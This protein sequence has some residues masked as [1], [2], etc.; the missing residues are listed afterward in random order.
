MQV[1]GY[2]LRVEYFRTIVDSGTSASSDTHSIR[3]AYP[4][5]VEINLSVGTAVNIYHCS[6]RCHRTEVVF[7][8][9]SITIDIWIAIVSYAVQVVV[10]LP[11]EIKISQRKQSVRQSLR[12]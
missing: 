10:G 5:Q 4:V 12:K 11:G 2:S 8:S 9:H 3:V 6:Q 1:V 7:I